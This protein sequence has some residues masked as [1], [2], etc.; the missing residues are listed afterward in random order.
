M[1]LQ[2]R[3]YSFAL[4]IPFMFGDSTNGWGTQVSWCWKFYE[5]WDLEQQEQFGSYYCH[6]L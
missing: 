6:N 4:R 5:Q 2:D 1:S 3:I